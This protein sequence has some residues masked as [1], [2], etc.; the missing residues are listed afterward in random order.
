[1][2]IIPRLNSEQLF[3]LCRRMKIASCADSNECAV[4]VI[5][6]YPASPSRVFASRFFVSNAWVIGCSLAQPDKCF[7]LSSRVL[8]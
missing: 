6:Y 7:S 3:T 8:R 4:T 2:H 5:C 1:M